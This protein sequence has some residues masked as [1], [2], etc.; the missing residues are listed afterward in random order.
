ME[1]G[2]GFLLI[3]ATMLNILIK[4]NSLSK[5]I[6]HIS[7]IQQDQNKHIVRLIYHKAKDIEDYEAVSKIKKAMP[8]DFD[9]F[10]FFM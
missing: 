3:G 10:K 9:Y 1:I 5:K 8:K 6:D 7:N 4:L 2:I